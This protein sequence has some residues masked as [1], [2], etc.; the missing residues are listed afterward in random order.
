MYW[1]QRACVI[2]SE[3]KLRYVFGGTYLQVVRLSASNVLLKKAIVEDTCGVESV[4][5]ASSSHDLQQLES[6]VVVKLLKLCLQGLQ[7]EGLREQFKAQSQFL[8]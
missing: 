8:P 7:H 5:T 2:E 6:A 3:S 1:A 4:V